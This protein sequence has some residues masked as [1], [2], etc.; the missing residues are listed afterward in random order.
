MQCPYCSAEM[1][2][3]IYED[4][5]I[6]ICTGCNGVWLDSHELSTISQRR[7]KKIDPSVMDKYEPTPGL[8]DLPNIHKAR[9]RKLAC[10]QCGAP[11]R[12]A[13]YGY[14]SGIVIDICPNEHGVFLDDQE[15]DAI[16]AW[17]EKNDDQ[18]DDLDLYYKALAQQS[19]GKTYATI[20]GSGPSMGATLWGLPSALGKLIEFAWKKRKKG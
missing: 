20:G 18:L 16:Q 12:L 2:G 7:E 8:K 15:I 1:K 11:L 5:R 19:A 17:V 13:N 9:G 10:P 6:D 4:A 14:S 3:E